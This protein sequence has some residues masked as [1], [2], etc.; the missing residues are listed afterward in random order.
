MVRN[1][2]TNLRGYSLHP[3]EGVEVT[4]PAVLRIID[5]G[6]IEASVNPDRD[7]P[8]TTKFPEARGV[9][10]LRR[11]VSDVLRTPLFAF[12]LRLFEGPETDQNVACDRFLRRLLKGCGGAVYCSITEHPPKAYEKMA[13]S[14]LAGAALFLRCFLQRFA[15]RFPQNHG[16]V[17]PTIDHP[18]RREALIERIGDGFQNWS[19]VPATRRVPAAIVVRMTNDGARALARAEQPHSWIAVNHF[20]EFCIAQPSRE[21]SGH[22][23]IFIIDLG[24]LSM[25]MYTSS[26]IAA[27]AGQLIAAMFHPEP[28]SAFVVAHS[29]S[30]FQFVWGVAKFFLTE[31]ARQKF[32]VLTGSASAHFHNKLGIPLDEIPE[33]VGGTGKEVKVFSVPELLRLRTQDDAIRA[34]AERHGEDIARHEPGAFHDFSRLPKHLAGSELF[35]VESG[36]SEPGTPT[37]SES[38]DALLCAVG[39][40]TRLHSGTRDPGVPLPRGDGRRFWG[41]SSTFSGGAGS[42]SRKR[43]VATRRRPFAAAKDLRFKIS[44]LAEKLEKAGVVPP[45]HEAAKAAALEKLRDMKLRLLKMTLARYAYA[46]ATVSALLVAAYYSVAFFARSASARRGVE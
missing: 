9:F 30:A 6:L 26:N 20:Y 43:S 42:G 28:F 27:I 14:K 15:K 37:E 31:S 46:W 22:P 39:N 36:C 40:G 23:S 45:A 38:P 1:A 8:D 19:F 10:H 16:F 25:M 41:E 4:G 21:V 13:D 5:C 12:A 3:W 32:V 24:K 34:Y 7:R 33:T 18:A 35:R 44:S 11:A 29:P 2:K 17:H